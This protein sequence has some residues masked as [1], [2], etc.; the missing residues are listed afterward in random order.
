MLVCDPGSELEARTRLA[1]IGFDNVEG[2]LEDPYGVVGPPRGGRT[3]LE[4]TA[5]EFLQ[6]RRD[7][8]E[9]VVVDVRNPGETEAGT[10]EV[11]TWCRSPVCETRWSSWRPT[12]TPC[13][14]A[15]RSGY[16]S[17]IAASLLRAN[18][19]TDVSDVL[20]GYSALV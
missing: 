3:R 5:E 16:R 17:S 11:P 18:R 12:A 6:R 2:F 1:R 19:F 4:L 9:L 13:R 8:G 20:R 15:V 14:D 7:I 10:L